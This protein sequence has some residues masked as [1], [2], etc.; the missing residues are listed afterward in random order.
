MEWIAALSNPEPVLAVYGEAVPELGEVRIEEVVL[1][2]NGPTLRFRFDLPVFPVNP[3]VKW[4]RDGLD[5]VQIEIS[6]GCLRAISIEKFTTDSICD[7]KIRKDGVVSFSGD[8]ES[9]KFRGV[10]DTA[11]IVRVSAY[12][13]GCA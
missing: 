12:A 3:P 1:S 7:L 6:L 4:Q 13:M 8:S 11:T 10:A 5:V 2:V 9:V